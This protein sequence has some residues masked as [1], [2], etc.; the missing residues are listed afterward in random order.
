MLSDLGVIARTLGRPVCWEGMAE[1][2]PAKEVHIWLASGAEL[3]VLPWEELSDVRT[4]KA[5]LQELCGLPRFRQRL[6][7][8]GT[9]L[10]DDAKLGTWTDLQVVLLSFL[11]PAPE[12]A[13]ALKFAAMNGLVPQVEELLQG[14]TDPDASGVTNIAPIVGAALE[15]HVDVV[16]L[17]L[18]A[19][20][21]PDSDDPDAFTPLAAACCGDSGEEL[22]RAL[23]EARADP[24][25]TS[26][27]GTPLTWAVS[28]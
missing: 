13:D 16:R 11:P 17:L 25:R 24:D 20:A 7:H 9:V 3:T 19:D 2:S 6:L 1:D 4:L 28:W 27:R 26:G 8:E 21:A 22:V 15:G 23:L 5:Q 12:Q 10:A 14:P 18:E